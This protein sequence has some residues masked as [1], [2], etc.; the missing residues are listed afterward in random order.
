MDNQTKDANFKK[1]KSRT[2]RMQ[3]TARR[4]SVVSAMSCA[5]RRLIR[6]VR[7]ETEPIVMTEETTTII[8]LAAPLALSCV[9]A[10][11]FKRACALTALAWAALIA[12]IWATSVPYAA[13]SLTMIVSFMMLVGF[14]IGH[15]FRS[16]RVRHRP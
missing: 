15:L 3:A 16:A 4:L 9:I 6:S 11:L 10:A 7:Q 1:L 14:V 12:L 5:R 13:F 8:V 2:K